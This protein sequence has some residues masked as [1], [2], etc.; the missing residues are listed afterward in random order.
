MDINVGS[1][2]RVDDLGNT[3]L[4]PGNYIMLL[5]VDKN[6]KERDRVE[7]ELVGDK[8]VLDEWPQPANGSYA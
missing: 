8:V 7:F 5:D 3:V 2:A 1:L 4:F 6:G